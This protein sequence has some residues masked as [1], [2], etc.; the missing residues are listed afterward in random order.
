VLRPIAFADDDDRS[1]LPIAVAARDQP[2]RLLEEALAVVLEPLHV[3]LAAGGG[4]AGAGAAGAWGAALSLALPP[5]E[6][7]DLELPAVELGHPAERPFEHPHVLERDHDDSDRRGV[8]EQRDQRTK[9]RTVLVEDADADLRRL[10]AVPDLASSVGG[11]EADVGAVL[12]Q[13]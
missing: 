4:G 12:R 6:S 10:E 13:R 7:G 3:L 1:P 2:S 8:V 5:V 9:V 11:D